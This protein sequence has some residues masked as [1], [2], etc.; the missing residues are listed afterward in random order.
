MGPF[1]N[2]CNMMPTTFALSALSSQRFD[3]FLELP[4]KI[5]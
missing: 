4:D 5:H 3:I 2:T 1:C